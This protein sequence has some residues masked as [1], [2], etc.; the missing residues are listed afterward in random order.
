ML[1]RCFRATVRVFDRTLGLKW[2][3]SSTSIFGV[4]DDG[5]ITL[6]VKAYDSL[7]N[8]RTSSSYQWN[9]NT[10]LPQTILSISGSEVNGYLPANNLTIHLTPPSG[11]HLAAVINWSIVQ[12]DGSVYASGL[13][14]STVSQLFTNMSDGT[15]WIN[16]T[17]SDAFGRSVQR[18]WNY[19]IDGT[20]G[21]IPILSISEIVS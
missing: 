19:T 14:N 10:S 1:S 7:N 16:V 5:V 6:L 8:H 18:S 21:I 2:N 17:T 12:S 9:H 11:S 15:L 20:V 13:N 4:K 3:G